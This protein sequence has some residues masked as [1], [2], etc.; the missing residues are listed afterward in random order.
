MK[1][2]DEMTIASLEAGNLTVVATGVGAY[3]LR[4]RDH[5]HVDSRAASRSLRDRLLVDG[6]AREQVTVT[7]MSQTGITEIFEGQ[8]EPLQSLGWECL[9]LPHQHRRTLGMPRGFRVTP[10]IS[11]VDSG[12]LREA[13]HPKTQEFLESPYLDRRESLLIQHG[14]DVVG[15]VPIWRMSPSTSIIRLTVIH[16]SIY[17]DEERRR[18]HLKLTT[19]LQALESQCAKGRAVISWLPD[20]DAPVNALKLSVGSPARLSHWLSITVRRDLQA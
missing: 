10:D 7:F 1:G 18:T 17:A 3:T 14:E 13:R 16:P 15:W 2:E 4:T 19:Y 5:A 9:M 11:Q 8:P 6:E 20:N 12:V